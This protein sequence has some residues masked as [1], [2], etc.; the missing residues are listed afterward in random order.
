MLPCK[1][2]QVSGCAS[3]IV[4]QPIKQ[5]TRNNPASGGNL[6][7]RRLL[8]RQKQAVR[9]ALNPLSTQINTTIRAIPGEIHNV[10]PYNMQRCCP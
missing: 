2:S 7:E 10:T 4:C 9:K 1:S 3:D 8:N 5:V 6:L